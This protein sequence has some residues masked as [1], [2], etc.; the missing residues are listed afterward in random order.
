MNEKTYTPLLNYVVNKYIYCT[1][2]GNKAKSDFNSTG[3]SETNISRHTYKVRS[4]ADSAKKW[5]N[6][7]ITEMADKEIES[8]VKDFK[9]GAEA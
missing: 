2:E 4:W 1:N 8:L 9:E 5:R 7:L 3:Q 6:L